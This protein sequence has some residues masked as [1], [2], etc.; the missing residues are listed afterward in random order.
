MYYRGVD[1][2]AELDVT[3]GDRGD[4]PQGGCHHH[5]VPCRGQLP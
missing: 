4:V 2:E 1:S 3:P 5:E